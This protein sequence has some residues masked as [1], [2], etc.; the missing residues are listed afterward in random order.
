[1]PDNGAL[2]L[3]IVSSCVFAV[4]DSVWESQIP[5]S[6]QSLFNAASGKQGSAMAN[7]KM[8]QS[9]GFA[10]QF[11]LGYQIHDVHTQAL[12]LLVV[13]LFSCIA[14]A[15]LHGRVASLDDGTVY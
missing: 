6:L 2:L 12:V 14:L 13:L 9:L 7:L 15:I 11:A 3:M 4:G 8:W 1:M 10:I 5:A